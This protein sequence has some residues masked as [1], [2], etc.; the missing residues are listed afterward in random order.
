MEDV[1]DGASSQECVWFTSIPLSGTPFFFSTTMGLDQHVHGQCRIDSIDSIDAGESGGRGQDEGGGGEGE[2]KSPLAVFF[3]FLSFLSFFSSSSSYF[4]FFC[5][6]FHTLAISYSHSL[7]LFGRAICH[8]RIAS[9]L[10]C[11]L[12]PPC[13]DVFLYRCPFTVW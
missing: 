3:L 2:K 7:P 11:L 12:S 4:F 10:R 8:C 13:V 1:Q 5:R 6:P 9:N